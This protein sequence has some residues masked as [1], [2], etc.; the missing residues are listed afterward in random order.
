MATQ[1][2]VEQYGTWAV[3]TGA[4]DGVGGATA[5][6][7]AAKGMNL[8]LVARRRHILEEQAEQLEREYGVQTRVIAADLSLPDA[9]QDVLAQTTNLDVGLLVAAAGYGTSGQFLDSTIEREQDMLS[10]NVGAVL[11]MTHHYGRRFVERGRGGIILFSSLVAFQGVPNAANYA[12]TKG[13]IQSLAEGLYYELAPYGVDVLSSAP[14]PIAS[15]FAARAD[16]QM[17]KALTPEEV[18]SETIAALGKKLTVRPGFLS[19]FLIGG[20]S[21]LPR[22]MRVRVM[23]GIMGGMTAHQ[24][25]A[26]ATPAKQ[27]A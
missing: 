27:S 13:Y 6:Q 12:A 25:S 9:V 3:V 22:A 24:K 17:G 23:Q 19:K 26:P 2:W 15:G 5:R 20:L 11:T 1:K 18:A 4:S 14:G 10:V 8:V 7:L 21:T 16:M